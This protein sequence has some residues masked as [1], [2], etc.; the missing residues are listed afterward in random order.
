MIG[1]RFFTIYGEWGRPDMFFLKL[2]KSAFTKEVFNLNNKGNHHRDFTY[3]GDIFSLINSLMKKKIKGH[4]VYN[5]CSNNPVDISQ[6]VKKVKKR[7]SV[8]VK[9]RPLQKADIIKTHGSNNKIIKQTKF[10]DFMNIDEGFE[11]TLNWYRTN[12][13]YK[14]K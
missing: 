6:I 3:I 14:Y 9:L 4:E 10:K 8:K 2:F 1:M 12:K 7:F 11:A 13:I 5:F